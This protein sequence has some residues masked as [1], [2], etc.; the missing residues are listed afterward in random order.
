MSEVTGERS[1]WIR[2]WQ[3]SAQLSVEGAFWTERNKWK[4]HD[5]G[6]PFRQTCRLFVLRSMM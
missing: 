2:I 4:L 1:W 6:N 3:H 5:D